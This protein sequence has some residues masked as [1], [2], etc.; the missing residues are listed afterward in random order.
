VIG[1]FHSV[2]DEYYY[3]LVGYDAVMVSDFYPRFGGATASEQ[4][5]TMVT[6]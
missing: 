1:D 3:V 2:V 6:N 5:E 4:S